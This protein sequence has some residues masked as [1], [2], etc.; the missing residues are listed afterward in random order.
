MLGTLLRPLIFLRNRAQKKRAEPERR[1]H[2]AGR[3]SDDVAT[4]RARRRVLTG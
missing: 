1:H 4:S 3:R 2:L